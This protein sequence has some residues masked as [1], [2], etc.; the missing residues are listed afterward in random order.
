VSRPHRKRWD[1]YELRLHSAH[2]SDAPSAAAF[3]ARAATAF[4]AT[5]VGATTVATT[6][7][8]ADRAPTSALT[9]PT[10][11]SALHQQLYAANP[12]RNNDRVL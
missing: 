11:Y 4:A 2:A 8:A 3:A 10:W 7:A 1:H 9:G 5:A 6:V 12:A